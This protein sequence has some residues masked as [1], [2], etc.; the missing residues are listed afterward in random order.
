MESLEEIGKKVKQT[1]K[2]L[3]TM[4]SKEKNKVLFE[5]AKAIEEAQEQLIK[6]NQKDTKRAIKN[7]MKESLI[8]RLSLNESRILNMAE[9]IRKIVDLD[10]PIGET[11]EGKT[12]ENGLE[13]LKKRVPLGVIAI[14][15][16][17]RPNVT[18]DAFG[19]CFKTGNAVILRGGSD[20]IETN[21]ELRC[22]QKEKQP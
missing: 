14:I 19:L 9:G 12:L 20:A 16:E 13:I 18:L 15:Y 2:I 22:D 10:D 5:V 8:D 11:I 7:G 1:T 4:S 6:A 17:S 21:I 3:S